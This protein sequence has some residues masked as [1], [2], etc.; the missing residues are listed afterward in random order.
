MDARY[1]QEAVGYGASG[2]SRS[3]NQHIYLF[4]TFFFD[5]ISQH[6]CHET[7]AY[8]FKCQ[9][10]AVEQFKAVYIV[11]DMNH[12]G[13]ERQRVF[14]DLVQCFRINIFTEES[15]CYRAGYFVER[16][17]L[18]IVDRALVQTDNVLGHI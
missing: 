11:V 10:R 15:L 4:K 16:L 8:V 3:G 2:I 13:V 14:Y 9:C 5:E 12:W 6:T 1:A 17:V 7:A 18:H